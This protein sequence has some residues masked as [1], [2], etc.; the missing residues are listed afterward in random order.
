M[1]REPGR[2]VYAENLGMITISIALEFKNT[3]VEINY[4]LDLDIV[5]GGPV[6]FSRF[7]TCK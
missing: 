1:K 4:D 3:D 6:F 7:V 2:L 5:Y